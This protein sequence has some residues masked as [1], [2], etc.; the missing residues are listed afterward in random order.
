MSNRQQAYSSGAPPS[1]SAFGWV[2][3]ALAASVAFI[4]MFGRRIRL[5]WGG[6]RRGAGGRW[7]MD[8]SLGGKM[9]FIP[10]ADPTPASAAAAKQPRPLWGDDAAGSGAAAAATAAA[11]AGPWGAAPPAPAAVPAEPDWWQQAPRFLV[12]ATAERKQELQRQARAV[13][14][15]L[16]D[17]KLLQVGAGAHLA[18]AGISLAGPGVPALLIQLA[19]HL[20]A[21]A[22]SPS[23]AWTI[24]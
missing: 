22:P 3:L 6:G 5:P 8:R 16:E 1:P 4:L 9:I 18:C 20:L 2:P 13:L 24:R 21:A 17:A 7:V 15:Q 23:R 11:D 10:D 12:Y 19:A 14:R